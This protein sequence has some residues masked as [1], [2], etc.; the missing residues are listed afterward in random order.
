MKLICKIIARGTL[1]MRFSQVARWNLFARMAV[2]SSVVIFVSMTGN[3]AAAQCSAPVVSEPPK[4]AVGS[5]PISVATEDFNGDGIADLAVA[6][7]GSR[8]I[9]ILIGDGVGGFGPPINFALSGSPNSL[10]VGDFNKDGKADLA[11][12]HTGGGTL[13]VLF[14]NGSGGFAPTVLT[15]NI[16]SANT[17]VVGDFNGDT[18]PDIAVNV[19]LSKLRILLGNGD[20]SFSITN[21]TVTNNDLSTY[22]VAAD[23]NGDG[24]SDLAFTH[25]DLGAPRVSLIHGNREGN[26]SVRSSVPLDFRAP[27]A[28]AAADFNGDGRLD[29]AVTALHSDGKLY[30]LLNDGAGSFVINTSFVLDQSPQAVAT[31]DFNGDG[32]MDVVVASSSPNNFHVY[33]V[34][35]GNGLGNFTIVKTQYPVNRFQTSIVAR[36]F[37]GD[38]KTDLVEADTG[39]FDITI[40]FRTGR[41]VSVLFGDGAG[42]FDSSQVF[43]ATPCITVNDVTV[44]EGDSG[45]RNADF[46]VSLSEAST[47]T[48]RVNYS[49]KSVTATEGA[50]YTPVLGRLVFQPGE[51]SKTISVPVIGDALNEADDTFELNLASPAHASI[52]DATGVGTITNDDP[53]PV[54]S[55]NDITTTDQSGPFFERN[56][57]VTLSAPSGREVTVQYTAA[58]GTANSTQTGAVDYS[59]R[60]G[61]LRIPAGQ[62]TATIGVS[63]FS[64]DIFEPDE[65]FFINLS[66]PTNATIGDAQGMATIVNDDPVPTLTADAFPALEN[67]STITF[68]LHLSNPTSQTVTLKY[69]TADGTAVAGSDY[70]AASGLFTFAPLELNKTITVPIN[71]DALDE[72]DETFSLTLSDVVNASLTQAP[73]TALIRDND[74][75]VITINDI[76]VREGNSGT[77]DATFTVSLSAQSPQ[78]VR[79]N[80]STADGTATSASDYL[81]RI[82]NFLTIPAG[83]TSG[84]LIVSINGDTLKEP[85]ET[86]FVNLTSAALNGTIGDGQGV[87]TIVNDD[88]LLTG[89]LLQFSALT[90]QQNE[91]DGRA[92]LTV[93]RTGD[94]SGTATV[95]Y[96]TVD[97]D[98]FIIGCA[99]TVNNKG[100]AYARCDFS[101]TVG[102][103]L[104]AAGEISKTITVPLVDDGHDESAET[105]QLHL[106]NVTGAGMTLGAQNISNVTITDNDLPDAANPINTASPSDYP[107]FVRQQYLDF[108]SREP[109]ASEPWTAVLNRCPNI[110]TPP[111]AVTDCDRIAVSG[112]FFGSPEFRLK[113]FYVFRFYKV[114][115]NRLPQ[116]AEIV[117][118]M[119]FVAG[120]TEAEVYARKAQLA[121]AFT[122]RQ[123][124]NDAYGTKTNM[125]YVAALLARYQLA[126]VRTIDPAAPD[127][128]TKVTLTANDLVNSLQA[129]TL[130]RA[131][132]LR[133]VAESDEVGAAEY[134]SAFVAAQ[135]YGYLRRTPENSGYQAWLRVI[136]EDPNNIRIMVNGFMNSTEYRLRFGRP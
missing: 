76:S 89:G 80:F 64:D 130:T 102:T 95:D 63:I 126:A 27:T 29:V 106:S 4:Y 55:I 20:G 115:F 70:T 17:V 99:D 44:V 33:D 93:T 15:V 45:T 21:L 85:D 135:Y 25:H 77:T 13:S 98:N 31:A 118:D 69:A 39:G 101:T 96:R 125:E 65:N 119:S 43:S 88:E 56:F 36:D 28:I 10:A 127:G 59:L 133:A 11:V 108:L 5:E 32:K 52:G 38:G 22:M 91:G 75:P 112:A 120:Q 128:T 113:G 1:K 40:G 30:I 104:F 81:P 46:I 90:Y 122:A 82:N 35:L 18:N 41:T 105:F 61:T 94:T 83:A 23:F 49:L 67:A 68:N 72:V 110:H 6:N 34:F 116:Y 121:T 131:Q 24:L 74:G 53:L 7:K 14:G 111:S 109:E 114:A 97:T 134:N 78:N 107:F 87:G 79:V 37:N 19:E 57:T 86:F 3:N 51:T 12:G 50:D 117:S 16:S 62:T 92:T 54:L 100:G 47:Q 71:D 60:P 26:F 2:F 123:E 103:L 58:D 84:T 132:V 42:G 48:V 73:A 136:N 129:G 124:F 8:N 66:N 9:S